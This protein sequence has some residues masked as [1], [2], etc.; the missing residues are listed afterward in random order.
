[1]DFDLAPRDLVSREN[2]IS[3]LISYTERAQVLRYVMVAS[4]I[5]VSVKSTIKAYSLTYSVLSD[6]F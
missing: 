1:M 2:T 3:L 5:W 6:A 4:Y